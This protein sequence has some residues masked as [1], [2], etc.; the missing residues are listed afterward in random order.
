ML[1]ILNIEFPTA[2]SRW[3]ISP[4][5]YPKPGDKTGL[6]TDL[7]VRRMLFA[8][9]PDP[10]RTAWVVYEG[11]GGDSSYTWTKIQ[12]QLLDFLVDSVG[13]ADGAVCWASGTKGRKVRFWR[14]TAKYT[15]WD[16]M[17]PLFIDNNGNISDTDQNRGKAIGDTAPDGL[18][19]D[20]ITNWASVERLVNVIF[21]QAAR[22]KP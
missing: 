5:A 15:G 12:K 6:Q 1:S 22:E 13:Q 14:Y 9:I 16:K 20:I 19:L 11:K 2:A 10:E 17:V 21:T 18:C 4:E 3:S 8:G 7:L